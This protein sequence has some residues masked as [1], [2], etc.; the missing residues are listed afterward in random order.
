VIINAAAY[1]AVDRAER[2]AEAAMRV[3]AR[4][5][6][7]VA[8]ACAAAGAALFQVS[9][10]YVFDGKKTGA[11]R[12]DD[13]IAP[14]GAYGRSKAA[15]E[16]AVRQACPTHLIVR[17][18]WVFGVHGA[19]FVK[20]MVRLAA[21]RDHLDVVADQRGSPTWTFDLARALLAAARLVAGGERPWGT[22]HFAGS[23]E[24]TRHGMACRIV[25][26][27]RPFTGRSPRVNAIASA[28]YP[29][30]A[31]RPANSVLDS[32]KFARTFGVR[33]A[34]WRDAVDRTVAGLFAA[35]TPA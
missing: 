12:E 28:D 30:P 8:T 35:K 32:A 18:A 3:N 9:S 4:G 23:G 25:A 13:P 19:N 2:E 29:T 21:E 17:T 34:D 33:A 11:Y 26:A 31:A 5:P 1:N 7:V 16:E 22:Y 27:Q 24:T 15:G 20:T 14:L 10:D 6:A